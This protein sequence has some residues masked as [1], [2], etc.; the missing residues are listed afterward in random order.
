MATATKKP[1]AKKTTT[2]KPNKTAVKKAASNKKRAE[3]IQ[4]RKKPSDPKPERII[5]KTIKL[6]DGQEKFIWEK[7]DPVSATNASIYRQDVAGAILRVSEHGQASE[8]GWVFSLIDPEGETD[9]VN[10]V[11]AMHWMNAKVKRKALENWT[12]VVTGGRD[13]TGLFNQKKEVK[14][15]GIQ[16]TKSRKTVLFQSSR[17]EPRK[18]NIQ[19]RTTTGKK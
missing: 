4:T 14:I 8:F 16:L 19:I 18:V 6:T 9:D 13:I 2:K 12:A 1:A 11:V 15:P 3:H 17:V 5:N 10:N 7:A